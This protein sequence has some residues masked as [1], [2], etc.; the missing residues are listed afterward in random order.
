MQDKV[1]T[2]WRRKTYF[3]V[4]TSLLIHIRQILFSIRD[5]L[6]SHI[7]LWLYCLSFSHTIPRPWL[8]LAHIST[9]LVLP[10][11]DLAQLHL[12]QEVSLDVQQEGPS[13][14]PCVLAL[15]VYHGMSPLA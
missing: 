8:H 3:S 12:I 10:T 2:F 6:D 13:P 15:F 9:F 14:G 4:R 1:L 5:C 11:Q 7:F